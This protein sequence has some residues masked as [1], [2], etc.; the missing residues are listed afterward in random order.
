MERIGLYYTARRPRP[1]LPDTRP[2]NGK[3]QIR[4]RQGGQVRLSRLDAVVAYHALG[5]A[6]KAT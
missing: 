4:D 3:Y 1:N 6:L 5:V 2:V